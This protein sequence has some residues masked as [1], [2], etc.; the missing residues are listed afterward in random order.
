MGEHPSVGPF[1]ATDSFLRRVDRKG[2]LK[3]GIVSSEVFKERQFERTLSFTFQDLGLCSKSGIDQY[4]IDKELPS[5]DLP[6]ICK[7]TWNDLTVSLEPPL[8]PRSVEDPGDKKYGHL[9]CCTDPPHNDEQRALM[10]YMAGRNAIVRDFV[11]KRK[12][13]DR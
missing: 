9:H 10:A 2:Y 3:N 12:R 7:L 1:G 6:G 8:P 4:Q 5:G 13:K 11:R